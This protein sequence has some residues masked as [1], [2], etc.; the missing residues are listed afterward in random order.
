M[1]QPAQTDRIAHWQTGAYID[2]D[3]VLTFLKSQAG[4]ILDEDLSFQQR[5][6]RAPVAHM[7]VTSL[8]MLFG[9]DIYL[10]WFEGTV[11]AGRHVNKWDITFPFSGKDLLMLLSTIAAGQR[12]RTQS[13]LRP[14]SLVSSEP[15]SGLRGWWG[16]PPMGASS[17]NAIVHYLVQ[18]AQ[19][20]ATLRRNRFGLN[21]LQ[22]EVESSAPAWAFLPVG[23]EHKLISSR[24]TVPGVGQGGGL[25][26]DSWLPWLQ[27]VF[28]AGSLK[29][30]LNCTDDESPLSGYLDEAPFSNFWG[31]MQGA[32][33]LA[34]AM[35]DQAK[36]VTTDQDPQ[37]QAVPPLNPTTGF[38]GALVAC[39]E[40]WRTPVGGWDFDDFDL[41]FV[42]G[43][44]APD[45]PGIS[46]CSAEWWS[47]T[48]EAALDPVVQEQGFL[49]WTALPGQG[50]PWDAEPVQ[51]TR[52]VNAMHHL[53]YDFTVEDRVLILQRLVNWRA[54]MCGI[55]APS[56]SAD[57]APDL[58]QG[59]TDKYGWSNAASPPP[60]AG[61]LP[62]SET[63]QDG[64]LA[65]G[66]RAPAIDHFLAYAMTLSRSGLLAPN[67]LGGSPADDFGQ[68][69]SLVLLVPGLLRAT[70]ALY[71]KSTDP[72]PYSAL[73]GDF[74]LLTDTGN[75][76]PWTEEPSPDPAEQLKEFE[77]AALGGTFMAIAGLLMLDRAYLFSGCSNTEQLTDS[78]VY[79]P[80][81]PQAGLDDFFGIFGSRAAFA[82]PPVWGAWYQPG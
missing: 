70:A 4:P 37:P 15:A 39:F 64:E 2:W 13:N 59:G 33:V 21:A 7:I 45:V 55:G 29:T 27:E 25:L 71:R 82:S 47:G 5:Q 57:P 1:L 23:L 48:A 58:V 46:C 65:A 38:G 14:E 41:G 62:S 30:E 60:E 44:F 63:C 3:G 40:A 12:G 54:P 32:V 76:H 35:R 52:A 75:G 53:G 26:T 51:L 56:S 49:G 11:L 50:Q 34:Q 8:E 18:S 6:Q 74:W 16:L 31:E 68:A 22:L 73:E 69:M 17:P 24:R 80:C 61:G 19:M 20:Y 9:Q 72:L 10:R 36:K 81:S 78:D 67:A 42:P 66:G 77:R 43:A 28:T 79:A